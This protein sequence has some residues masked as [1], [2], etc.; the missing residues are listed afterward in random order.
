MGFS[1]SAVLIDVVKDP[2]GVRLLRTCV[3]KRIPEE[4]E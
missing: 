2:E 4:E 3:Q 1:I